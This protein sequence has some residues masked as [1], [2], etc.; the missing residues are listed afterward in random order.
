[1]STIFDLE[2]EN[3]LIQLGE[4]GSRCQWRVGEIVCQYLEY[5]HDDRMR[6]Y[7]DAA[8]LYGKSERSIR[9]YAAVVLFYCDHHSPQFEILPFEYHATAM[10][11]PDRWYALLE[12]CLCEM[13]RTGGGLPG[14][15]WLRAL[16]GPSIVTS[17]EAENGILPGADPQTTVHQLNKYYQ[18]F[19]SAV[20]ALSLDRDIVARLVAAL[21]QL[22]A[23]I[24]EIAQELTAQEIGV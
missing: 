9:R 24:D 16:A 21:D 18:A 15:D 22:Q 12:A 17:Y 7:H 2:T 23:A 5:C 6:V 3:E 1:M 13:D 20:N 11:Y 19:M 4:T 10:Q 14:V 8:K